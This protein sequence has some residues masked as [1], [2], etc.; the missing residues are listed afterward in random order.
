MREE[1]EFSDVVL[2]EHRVPL[3][4]IF[5]SQEIELEKLRSDVLPVLSSS[6]TRG[7]MVLVLHFHFPPSAQFCSSPLFESYFEVLLQKTNKR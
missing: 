2:L 4:D 6:K 3:T 7:V 1:A 5:V